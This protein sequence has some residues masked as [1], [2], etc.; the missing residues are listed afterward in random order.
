MT[1]QRAHRLLVTGGAGFIGSN[2]VRST[3]KEGRAEH[4]V[5]LDKLTY[6]GNTLNL[7]PALTDPRHTF[8]HGD[9]C[10]GPLVA[11]LLAEHAIT[12]IIHFA[13]ESHV[14]RSIDGP[15]PFLDT[16]VGGTVELLEASRRY[17]AT[18]SPSAR[19][20]FRFVQVSTDEVF[21]A[22][23]AE[24]AFNERSPYAPNSPYSASKAAADHFARA[25]H[26]TYGL[27]V[28][29][30]HCTNNYGP[31]Q[32]PEKLVPLMVLNAL[33]RRPLPV[34]GRGTNVRD[35]IFVGDHCE[36]VRLA[37]ERGRPGESYLLGAKSERSNLE[38]VHAICALVDELRPSPEGP[39][40]ELIRF[41][42]DR[43]GHDF[44][45]AI[46]PSKAAS[47]L[48]FVARTTL[49]QGLRDT[50]RWYID[51]RDWCARVTNAKYDRE[52]LG[53]ST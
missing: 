19:D 27:P 45:Y 40:R 16:N 8:V 13:A 1:G 14:D 46:D 12:A 39:S 43:P 50:V 22:L 7:G 4:V 11:R 47:E 30:T 36:G 5:T 26:H 18:L 25:Y 34:Y 48:G 31:Y 9:I 28:V 49:E 6:A 17:F 51:H 42:E 10:D 38:L 29:T 20:S 37:L 44:R 35:W 2:F 52:R 21:G 3:L 33:D 15:R 23:G 32:F 53:R 24:G 41:V